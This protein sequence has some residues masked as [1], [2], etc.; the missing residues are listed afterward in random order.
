MS[1]LLYKYPHDHASTLHDR[2]GVRSGIIH[3]YDV[4]FIPKDHLENVNTGRG[5]SLD[6]QCTVQV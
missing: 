5:K 1:N 4:G 6:A 3:R 2:S